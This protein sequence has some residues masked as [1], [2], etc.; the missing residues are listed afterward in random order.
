MLRPIART[1]RGVGGLSLRRKL[2]GISILL[3]ATTLLAWAL[4]ARRLSRRG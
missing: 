3:I 4:G 1:G 2:L